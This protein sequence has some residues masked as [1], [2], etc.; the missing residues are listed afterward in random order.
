VIK[1]A[2]YFIAV[3]KTL[4]QGKNNKRKKAIKIRKGGDP[5]ISFFSVKEKISD[6]CE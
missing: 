4:Q 3:Q 6:F 1:I 2:L 5:M